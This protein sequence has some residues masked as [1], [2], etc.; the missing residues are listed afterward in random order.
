MRKTFAQVL[1]DGKVDAYREY[2]RLYHMFFD[3][4]DN[5]SETGIIGSRTSVY[6]NAAVGF[7]SFRFRE[8]AVSLQDFDDIHNFH[9][10]EKP[11]DFDIDYL[12]T[13]CEYIYN[14]LNEYVLVCHNVSAVKWN[15]FRTQI[16]KVLQLIGYTCIKDGLFFIFVEKD[17]A[18]IAASETVPSVLSYKTILYNHHSMKGDIEAK[19]E[20]LLKFAALIE[21]K[22][23]ELDRINHSFKS[24]LFNGFNN[25]NLRHNNID[26]SDKEHYH[27]YIA[28]MDHRELEKWYDELYRMCLLAILLLEHANR[29]PDFDQLLKNVNEKEPI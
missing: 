28:E 7:M 19:K 23:K 17:P 11:K 14:I 25:L 2:L 4:Y 22:D 12:V 20:V 16:S 21:P 27:R 5:S 8:T 6:H 9:F 24:D 15:L 1:N 18:V 26:P 3:K 29:K 10:E 13:F